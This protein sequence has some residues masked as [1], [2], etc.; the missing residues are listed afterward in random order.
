MVNIKSYKD[1]DRLILTIENCTGELAQ[2]V[3]TFL[4]D[5]LGMEMEAIPVPAV[6]PIKIEEEKAPDIARLSVALPGDYDEPEPQEILE[7]HIIESG[8]F[9]GMSIKKAIEQSGMKAIIELVLYSK[10][11][12]GSLKTD[13]VNFSK[14]KIAEDLQIR[15]MRI[16]DAEEARDFINLYYPII[17]D[18]ISQ[19][20]QMSGY[21]DLDSFFE[22]ASEE[23]INDAYQSLLQSLYKRVS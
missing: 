4:L 16:T 22:F 19:I 5:I 13:I 9:K 23:I 6:E 14:K 17:K 12:E 3:N 1:G 18:G 10:T 21:A 7:K 20:L 15:N 2:K 11:R 8:N